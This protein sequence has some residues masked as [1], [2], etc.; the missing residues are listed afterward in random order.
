[1]NKEDQAIASLANSNLISFSFAN[2]RGFKSGHHI[3]ILADKL[4]KVE[5]GEI[6]RLIVTMPPRHCKSLLC[7]QLFPAWYLGRNAS[8]QIIC[9][10][11]SDEL[12]RDFGRKVRNILNTQE[13]QAI[14]NTKLAE[15]SAAINKFNTT[16]EG[17]YIG[18]GVGGSITGRGADL[19]LIDDP[20][21]GREEAD[22]EV[23]RKKL[24][25]WY[26]SVART[27]LMP[28]GA[29]VVIQTRWHKD[30]LVGKLLKDKSEDWEVLN[31][32]AINE[33]EEPLW[34]Q[35]W[36]LEELLKTKNAIGG[37]EWSCLYQGV[38]ADPENQVFHQD[39][40]RYYDAVPPG[41]MPI[42]MTVDPAFKQ[43]KTSDYSCIMICG[44]DKGRTYVLDYVNKKLLPNDLISEILRLYN[45]WKPHYV[46]IEAF[47]A[48]SVIGFYLQEKMVTEGVQFSWQEIRQKG[49]KITKIKR[50]EPYFRNG[51]ILIKREHS[52]LEAQLLEFPQGD[53]D[54]II[55]AL[56]MSFEFRLVPVL[57]SDQDDMPEIE[58]SEYGEPV[59]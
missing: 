46:G 43:K 44:K 28:G 19:F 25:E 10:T 56:Q 35:M 13:Y 29:I 45:K 17:V 48:Q 30:D 15:D 12:S 16:K 7:S 50:L 11:Y 33:E 31:M 8:K 5:R 2:Y 37:R 58:Y 24:W 41:D 52:D 14:F 47:A 42:V 23:M 34:P 40:I 38:P 54:D 4:E 49:D 21:K 26:I 18:T 36:S 39:M 53:H 57:K 20:I 59:Y 1:M 55:D 6:K 3:R 27:R 32:P 22:S 9:A 51:Q